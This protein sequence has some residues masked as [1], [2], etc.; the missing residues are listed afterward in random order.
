MEIRPVGAALIHVDR[1]SRKAPK[2]CHT[3]EV[4]VYSWTSAELLNTNTYILISFTHPALEHGRGSLKVTVHLSK[5]Q[6]YF[7][8]LYIDERC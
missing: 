3:N 4:S 7:R 6:V 1:Q 5:I 2:N 8:R